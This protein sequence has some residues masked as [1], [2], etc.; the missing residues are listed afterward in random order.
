MKKLTLAIFSFLFCVQCCLG[1]ALEQ[2]HKQQQGVY[3]AN[4]EK[5]LEASNMDEEREVLQ[6]PGIREELKKLFLQVYENEKKYPEYVQC[7]TVQDSCFYAYQ[8]IAKALY[9]KLYGAPRRDFEFLRFPTQN[10]LKTRAAFFSRYPSLI[11]SDEELA[12]LFKTT[13]EHLKAAIKV[14]EQKEEEDYLRISRGEEVS[15]DDLEE[16]D[17]EDDQGSSARFQIND[18]LAEVSKELISVSFTMETYRPLDSALFVFL[19][20]KSVSSTL[21]WDFEVHKQRFTK[22]LYELFDSLSIPQEKL[23]A[24]I[25][26]LIEKAPRSQF[27]IINQILIPHEEAATCMYLSFGGG[28]RHSIYDAA[29]E[30]SY[31]EFQNSRQT[32]VFRTCRN[33]QARVIAGA[34][35]ENPHIKILRYTCI[36]TDTEEAYEAVVRE[37]IDELL[38]PALKQ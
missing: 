21:T 34:L 24:C 22:I 16:D 3:L 31:R 1:Y 25:H 26:T 15:E 5:A 9:C 19:S 35:F 29:F 38:A 11:F 18:T 17:L 37:A 27:G 23:S 30:E 10:L 32:E 7:I 13:P 14:S 33:F 20:N 6:D 8:V 36:P 28:F 12:K 4:I 2:D